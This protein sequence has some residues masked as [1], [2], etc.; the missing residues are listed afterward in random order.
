[1]INIHS[2]HTED[3]ILI[4]KL[5][6]ELRISTSEQTKEK[7][8]STIEEKQPHRVI[9]DLSELTFLDSAGLAAFISGYKLLAIHGKK[10][11]ISD[12][13][14]QPKTIFEISNM[15]KI[16]PVFRNLEDALKAPAEEETGNKK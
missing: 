9:L 7:I 3:G 12:L 11:A 15:Q 10:L 14:G 16:I 6:G 4:F 13:R 8:N 1:M 2:Y 5:I